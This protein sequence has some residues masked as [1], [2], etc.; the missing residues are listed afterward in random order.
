MTW[1]S[2][3][4]LVTFLATVK[5]SFFHE[6]TP[7]LIFQRQNQ[8][9]FIVNL[10][11]VYPLHWVDRPG[12]FIPNYLLWGS[13]IKG[14]CVQHPLSPLRRCFTRGMSGRTESPITV[15]FGQFTAE[16]QAL[17]A[18]FAN[19]AQ[20]ELCPHSTESSGWRGHV[21]VD[22]T[23]TWNTLSTDTSWALAEGQWSLY[24]SIQFEDMQRNGKCSNYNIIL[25]LSSTNE[26]YVLRGEKLICSQLL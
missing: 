25:I 13:W 2:I 21:L 5:Q 8:I 1:C 14:V 15:S 11:R 7:R 22:N 20:L 19:F 24:V 3:E 26:L 17:V 9:V 4:I 18:T 6:R 10:N 12:F 23:S 16:W